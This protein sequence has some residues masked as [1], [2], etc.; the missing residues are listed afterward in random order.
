MG[1]AWVSLAAGLCYNR[2][3]RRR[4]FRMLLAL[5]VVA[6]LATGLIALLA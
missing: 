5:A 1:L 4:A 3:G 6:L 2:A